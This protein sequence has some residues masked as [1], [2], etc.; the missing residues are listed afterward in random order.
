MKQEKNTSAFDTLVKKLFAEIFTDQQKVDLAKDPVAF[1]FFSSG[2]KQA[3]TSAISTLTVY[4][5]LSTKPIC[6]VPAT[7]Q[8]DPSTTDFA[9]LLGNDLA[10]HLFE[11][12]P[13]TLTSQVV[14][15]PMLK[16]LNPMGAWRSLLKLTTFEEVQ[17]RSLTPQQVDYLVEYLKKINVHKEQLYLIPIITYDCIKKHREDYKDTPGAI[18]KSVHVYAITIYGEQTIHQETKRGIDIKP[19]LEA[20]IT[21]SDDISPRPLTEPLNRPMF[22]LLA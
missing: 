19:I 17:R 13:N 18:G 15:I 8:I 11:K 21:N 1:D 12:Y 2:I 6:T 5:P 14:G 20:S 7:N 4:H 10:E 9:K 22:L 3:A 16:R